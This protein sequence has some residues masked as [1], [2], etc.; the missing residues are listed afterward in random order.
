MI[1]SLLKNKD[2]AFFKCTTTCNLH[3]SYSKVNG[4]QKRQKITPLA[5]F[6]KID[7]G[8]SVSCVSVL[9]YSICNDETSKWEQTLS[10]F[11][12][13]TNP[14]SRS[15]CVQGYTPNTQEKNS[16][17]SEA[18]VFSSYVANFSLDYLKSCLKINGWTNK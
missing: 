5:S 1:L 13:L 9:D 15:C 16:G 17:E 2:V 18:Q 3:V 14:R 6:W 4:G 11:S 7:M 8:K 10:Q 12:R